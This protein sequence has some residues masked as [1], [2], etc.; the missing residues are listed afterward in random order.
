MRLVEGGT[1]DEDI[2]CGDLEAE[3]AATPSSFVGAEDPADDGIVTFDDNAATE[4]GFG[5][6]NRESLLFSAAGCNEDADDFARASAVR[7][8]ES[9]LLFSIASLGAAS[10]RTLSTTGFFAESLS[11]AATAFSSEVTDLASCKETKMNK[12]THH[13]KIIFRFCLP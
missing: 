4:A 12:T 5:F 13:H 7:L 3:A 11:E 10:A 1:V 9:L 8:V 2:S 6:C